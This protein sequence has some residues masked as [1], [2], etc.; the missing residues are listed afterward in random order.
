M[1]DAPPY[2]TLDATACPLAGRA[3]DGVAAY[4]DDIFTKSQIGRAQRDA[5][6]DLLAKTFHPGDSVLELNC[7]TGEDAIFLGRRGVSVLALD[8]SAQ[9]VTVSERRLLSEAPSIPV[10]FRQLSTERIEDLGCNRRFDGVFSNFSGLNCVADLGATAA[11][12]SGLV[13]P[14]ASLLLCLSSRYCVAEILYFLCRGNPEKAFRRCRG[15]S[16]ATIGGIEIGV[17]YLSVRQLRSAF[18]PHFRLVSYRG[19]GVAVPPSYC[20]SWARNHP[21]AFWLLRRIESAVA[22]LPI[23]RAS[24]D[25]ILLHLERERA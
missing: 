24:G 9:M 18:L 15:Y 23:L 22:S 6:W 19:V 8:A 1:N 16:A 14:G 4:Y 20:D 17:H 3:F 13:R 10:E 7:G 21:R 2:T 25:H 12:L 11:D 5:V